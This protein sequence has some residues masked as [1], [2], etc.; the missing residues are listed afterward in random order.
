MEIIT[1]GTKGEVEEN[2]DGHRRTSATLYE[3][4]GRRLLI[5]FGRDLTVEDFRKLNP[6]YVLISHSH[7]D[8]IFGLRKLFSVCPI[9]V[10]EDT[11]EEMGKSREFYKGLLGLRV[12]KD[13]FKLEPFS[14][15]IFDVEH[16]VVAPAVAIRI[17]DGK[18]TV[19]HATD[20]A[21]MPLDPLEEVDVYVGD[22]S[23]LTE[24]TNIRRAEDGLIGHASI[25]RQLE[26]CRKAGV[27]KAIF[28]HFGIWK[29]DEKPKL[30]AQLSK[31]FG[32]NVHLS[33]DGRTFHTARLSTTLPAIYLPESHAGK[34]ARKEKT[35]IVK[36]RKFEKY[37]DSPIFFEDESNVHGILKLT[38]VKGPL[39]REEIEEMQNRH[40][41]TREQIE[42]WWKGVDEFYV[43]E[44]QIVAVFEEPIPH[45]PKRG[46]QTF[47]I[48]V[49]LP[50]CLQEAVAEW[51]D[52]ALREHIADLT[53]AQLRHW[54]AKCWY[55]ANLVR[56]K[57]AKNI[58]RD[59]VLR[60][61]RF[62]VEEIKKRNLFKPREELKLEK[63]ITPAWRGMTPKALAEYI[64]TL[65]D[66]TLIELH[67][68]MHKIWKKEKS[69]RLAEQHHTVVEEF[70]RRD[71]EHLMIDALDRVKL[72]EYLPIARTGVERG[73][74]ITLSEMRELLN[75]P[76]YLK[77]PFILACGGIV[78]D[79]KTRGDAD[80]LIRFP[81][82][83]P[84]RDIPLEFR[85]GRAVMK[86]KKWDGRLHF[87]YEELGGVFTDH[88]PLYDLLVVPCK[89]REVVK[90]EELQDFFESQLAGKE[91][92]EK[93]ALAEAQ[94]AREED[95]VRPM[96]F[97][98]PLKPT[99][100]KI[101]GEKYTVEGVAAL[102][103]EEDYPCA[104]QKKYDGNWLQIMK[105]E[106]KILIRDISGVDVT[107][108][109]PATVKE[110]RGWAHPKSVT[111]ISDTEKWTAKGEFIGRELVAGY[112]HGKEEANDAG[113][114]HNVFDV[115]YFYDEKLRK[116]DINCQ[117][118][119]L[120][121]EPYDVRLKYLD[122]L[123]IKQSTMDAPNIKTCFNLAPSYIAKNDK[124]L[125]KYIRLADQAE[126]SE[127]AV[128]KSLKSTY[129]LTG[130]Q[131]K[132][133]KYKK[134]FE[135]HA[136]I[137]DVFRTKKKGIFV[138]SLGLS[139]PKEW[140]AVRTKRVGK[141]EYLVIG[142]SMNIA[143]R[144]PV[145]T[146]VSCATE[147]VFYYVDPETGSRQLVTY[148][149][150]ILGTRPE[151][152]TPDNAADVLTAAEKGGFLR[153]KLEDLDYW[154]N[155]MTEAGLLDGETIY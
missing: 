74:V 111:L 54:Y 82:R 150:T 121:N 66:E 84:E 53:D 4:E 20:V 18:T 105:M 5:D 136:I 67:A 39:S 9:Y 93:K 152:T 72:E 50:V 69:E 88:L 46:V 153:E 102:V 126:A 144:I 29:K 59:E 68:A 117:I 58:E 40:R 16:S 131:Q 30:A 23:Y 140:K 155:E 143:E 110:M 71:L 139:L 32:V 129:K 26:W 45:K 99:I 94:K 92:K 135:L 37:L 85:L 7:P 120:H 154:K 44:F 75:K 78:I 25:K 89:Y 98:V 35:L 133:W 142:K 86:E 70:L 41:I 38:S 112:L 104:V 119:D 118:G 95:K 116:H 146:I 65:S 15:R 49:T 62:V 27:N 80:I 137:L 77:R 8:H 57:K 109:L 145:G 113:I 19:L 48:A 28:T 138:Y 11:Y 114:I 42:K 12:M 60:R 87:L 125:K 51:P 127:G 81:K 47:E 10:S 149:T 101:A 123:P 134:N 103:S 107:E 108:R 64:I 100:G 128:I 96:E 6:S 79:G 73:A 151:Q 52:K 130:M 141:E 115:I 132:W 22:G 14:I 148:V 76:F 36:T 55:W 83:I 24:P 31:E 17:S 106:N 2:F 122:L 3:V 63:E 33:R 91:I 21:W 56:R 43:Y 147:E 97:V 13:S 34:I 1:Y 61:F 90:M 124:E